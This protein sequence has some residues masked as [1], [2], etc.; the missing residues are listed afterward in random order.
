MKGRKK[1]KF[2]RREGKK[3]KNKRVRGETIGRL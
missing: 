2:R 3:S 1:G